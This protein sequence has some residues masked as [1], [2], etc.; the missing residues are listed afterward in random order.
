V[1]ARMENPA[2]AASKSRQDIGVLVHNG[3]GV[4]YL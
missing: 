2:G 3:R 4:F 1:Q